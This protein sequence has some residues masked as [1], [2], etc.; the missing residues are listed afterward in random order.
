MLP[1]KCVNET[2]YFS[3]LRM[4]CVSGQ[5]KRAVT[6]KVNIIGRHSA[7]PTVCSFFEGSAQ[8][9]VFYRL[10]DDHKKMLR[11]APFPRPILNEHFLLSCLSGSGHNV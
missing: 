1:Y 6:L 11:N 3:N 10:Q 5:M 2:G 9:L 4:R 7:F 8:L